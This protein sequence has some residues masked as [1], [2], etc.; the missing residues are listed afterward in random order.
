MTA[1]A[2]GVVE[3]ISARE[4]AQPV[5]CDVEVAVHVRPLEVVLDTVPNARLLVHP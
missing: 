2:G 4:M 1:R 3:L 5:L